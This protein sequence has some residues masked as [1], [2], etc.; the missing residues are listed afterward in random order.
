M[1]RVG[2][3]VGMSVATGSPQYAIYR[4]GSVSLQGE[5]V[6]HE[7]G[8]KTFLKALDYPAVF[9]MAHQDHPPY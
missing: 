1:H 8:F 9:L 4:R 3:Y 7:T 2:I 5:R 6:N